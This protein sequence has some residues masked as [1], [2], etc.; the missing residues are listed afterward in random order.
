[1]RAEG[2]GKRVERQD[3]REAC[4]INVSEPRSGSITSIIYHTCEEPRVCVGAL[5]DVEPEDLG[6]G[7]VGAGD[8]SGWRGV[9]T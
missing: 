8:Q 4:Y 3:F 2:V 6:G 5:D 1:M 9:D 7:S